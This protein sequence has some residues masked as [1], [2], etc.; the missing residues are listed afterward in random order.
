MAAASDRP[1]S[2]INTTIGITELY[3]DRGVR[4]PATGSTEI[5]KLI[6]KQISMLTIKARMEYIYRPPCWLHGSFR[7][8]SKAGISTNN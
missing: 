1:E 5:A 4:L 6:A 8:A 2:C 3:I 7:V